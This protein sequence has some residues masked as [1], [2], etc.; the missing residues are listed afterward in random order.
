MVST[1]LWLIF[2]S[3][4]KSHICTTFHPTTLHAFRTDLCFQGRTSSGDKHFFQAT[5]HSS[6]ASLT[7]YTSS[8]CTIESMIVTEVF[9][10]GCSSSMMEKMTQKVICQDTSKVTIDHIDYRDYVYYK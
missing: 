9:E 2:L 6:H 3:S 4:Q 7:T 10:V 8:D 1:E 5:C